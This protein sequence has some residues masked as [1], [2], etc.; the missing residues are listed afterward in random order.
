MSDGIF[1]SKNCG[2]VCLLPQWLMAMP[3]NARWDFHILGYECFLPHNK[4]Q[5]LV[6]NTEYRQVSGVEHRL[7]T[8]VWRIIQTYV[9]CRIQTIAVR[10]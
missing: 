7:Q 3:D 8:N 5:G 1:A 10:S 6:Y 2:E 4:V 9:W